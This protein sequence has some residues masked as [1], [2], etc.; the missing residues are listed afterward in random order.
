[1]QSVSWH[2]WT[3]RLICDSYTVRLRLLV[4]ASSSQACS[5]KPHTFEHLVLISKM[6]GPS[7]YHFFL[8]YACQDHSILSTTLSSNRFLGFAF[9]TPGTSLKHIPTNCLRHLK[10]RKIG[11]N[12]G[13]N[14]S[15]NISQIPLVTNPGPSVLAAVGTSISCSNSSS[16]PSSMPV[17][18]SYPAPSWKVTQVA[19][20]PQNLQPPG[21]VQATIVQVRIPSFR[22]SHGFFSGRIIQNRWTPCIG[23][24][25]GPLPQTGS[26]AVRSQFTA[27]SHL[28]KLIYLTLV[29]HLL[30]WYL[31]M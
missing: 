10:K 20:P 12:N 31:M 19:A 29:L 16:S 27:I 13:V 28:N 25:F 7:Q 9:Q 2:A 18:W 8:V 30:S 21:I 15:G 6:A 23:F 26:I 3:M 22:F 1:M 24:T 5:L 17:G 14:L 4:K 11:K